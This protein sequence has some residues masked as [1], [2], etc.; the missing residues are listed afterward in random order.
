MHGS[1]K[2]GRTSYFISRTYLVREELRA[3]ADGGSACTLS[4]DRTDLTSLPYPGDILRRTLL[5]TSAE[6]PR[7]API[8][9]PI[10]IQVKLHQKPS[11]PYHN[12]MF[13][14]FAF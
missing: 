10:S 14:S 4:I 8:I 12:E 1:C 9:V 2:P 13:G 11:K 7:I 6:D 3:D 5:R